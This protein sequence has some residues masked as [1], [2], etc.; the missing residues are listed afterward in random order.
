MAETGFCKVQ[1]PYR[2]ERPQEIG[3][4]NRGKRK[5]PGPEKRKALYLWLVPARFGP[6][7]IYME[8]NE[9]LAR[10]EAKIAQLGGL[11][12]EYEQQLLRTREELASLYKI[13]KA[14][15]AQVEELTDK[16][17]ELEQTGSLQPVAQE[18]FRFAT[19]QRINELVREIDECIALLNS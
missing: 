7:S 6:A 4:F 12:R 10:I 9:I 13:N 11:R 5:K 8:H 16:N 18:D 19:R 2:N 3:I 1:L 17:R 14:L 15:Q